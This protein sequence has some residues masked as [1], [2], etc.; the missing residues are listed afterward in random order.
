MLP[1]NKNKQKPLLR[2]GVFSTSSQYIYFWVWGIFTA[3]FVYEH[4]SS[5]NRN[6]GQNPTFIT[7]NAWK[8]LW[9]ND[10]LIIPKCAMKEGAEHLRILS[11]T[12]ITDFESV[13]LSTM[14]KNQAA[15]TNNI[16]LNK[17]FVYWCYKKGMLIAYPKTSN[18]NCQTCYV[19]I[20]D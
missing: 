3:Y 18:P 19:K 4:E 15:F 11:L 9:S 13:F 6:V 1:S 12:P 10:R 8:F 2:P 20:I 14:K 16:M 5:I 17:T 7:L